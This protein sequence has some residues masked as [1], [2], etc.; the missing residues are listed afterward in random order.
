MRIFFAALCVLPAIA[1]AVTPA[2][3]VATATIAGKSGTNTAG[4]A[5]FFKA[6]GKITLTVEVTGLTPGEHAIHIHEKGDC[7]DPEAKNA[8]GHWNPSTQ[9]HGQWEHAPFHLGDIGN[10]KAG[11]DGKASLTL[12]TD[13]WT[14]GGGG[15]NDVV[16]HAI[17]V[18]AAV[19]DFK[20]QPTGNAG[21]RVGCAV[22][23]AAKK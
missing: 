6:G 9:A 13:K 7:S 22:I 15:T 21:G 11:A 16:G 1:F 5:K 4:T 14:V 3:P 8:G 12:T 19:D 20:T 18:H 2:S 17:V 23:E 10:L